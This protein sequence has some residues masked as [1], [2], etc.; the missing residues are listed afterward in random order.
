MQ[1]VKVTKREELPTEKEKGDPSKVRRALEKT[2]NSCSLYK[3]AIVWQRLGKGKT[4]YVYFFDFDFITSPE[5]MRGEQQHDKD[6]SKAENQG[7][8]RDNHVQETD[9][10]VQK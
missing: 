5:M 8:T 4:I 1:T 7:Q 3:A 9:Q 6:E 2:K 10:P